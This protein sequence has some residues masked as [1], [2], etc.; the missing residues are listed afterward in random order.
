MLLI[1]DSLFHNIRKPTTKVRESVE[2]RIKSI[3]GCTVER[4]LCMMKENRFDNLF[5]NQKHLIL[6]IGTNSLAREKSEIVIG[7]F[8]RLLEVIRE[9]Y[10]TLET[11]AVCKVPTRTKTSIFYRSK[12]DNG[13]KSIRKRI[14]KFNRKLSRLKNEIRSDFNF[15]IIDVDFDPT[16]HLRRDGLHPNSIGVTFLSQILQNY[17]QTLQIWSFGFSLVF[18]SVQ[19]R[20]QDRMHRCFEDE[21][22]HRTKSWRPT[23][24][25]H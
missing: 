6:M 7:K 9:K 11:I 12:G 4:L 19:L 25:Q 15:S 24:L 23:V 16:V 8:R 1:G 3:G 2:T 18:L 17:A 13:G 21:I 14:E 5:E 22:F 20:S 10:S